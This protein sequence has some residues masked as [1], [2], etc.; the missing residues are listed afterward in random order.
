MTLVLYFRSS[1]EELELYLRLFR[2]SFFD[3]F[4]FLSLSESLLLHFLLLP[5]SELLLSSSLEDPFL[6]FLISFL[7]FST[8]FFPHT[9]V[10]LEEELDLFRLSFDGSFYFYFGGGLPSESDS[11]SCGFALGLI[12]F[13]FNLEELGLAFI[14]N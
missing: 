13:D 12:S 1:E 10:R 14:L 4:F 9:S 3:F 6:Y 8:N 7:V 11:D 5:L 2:L